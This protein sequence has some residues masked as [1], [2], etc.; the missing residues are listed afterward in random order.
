MARAQ[1]T[2]WIRDLKSPTHLTVATRPVF[3]DEEK[4]PLP[5]KG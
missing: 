3:R 2:P 5:G 4:P 1:K